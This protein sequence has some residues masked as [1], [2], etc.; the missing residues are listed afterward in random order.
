[1]SQ[2]GNGK[3]PKKRGKKRKS[4]TPAARSR[5]TKKRKTSPEDI[6]G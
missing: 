1:M 3:R 6:F 4:T 5:Q 2:T